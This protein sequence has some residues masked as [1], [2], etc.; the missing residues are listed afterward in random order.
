MSIGPDVLTSDG[1]DFDGTPP[2]DF[3][4]PEMTDQEL[5]EHEEIDLTPEQEAA[6]DAAWDSLGTNN[7]R[8]RD[9]LSPER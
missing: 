9:N 7:F 6:L 8:Q 2:D 5:E 1:D 3:D 4:Y